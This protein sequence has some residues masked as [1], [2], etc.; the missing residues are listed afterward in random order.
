MRKLKRVASKLATV[1]VVVPARVPA[2]IPAL[3]PTLIPALVLSLVLAAHSPAVAAAAPAPTN[4]ATAS[5]AA[6]VSQIAAHLGRAQGVRA[7]FTQ[8]QTLAAMK[9]PL[10]STGALLFY[11]ERGV[12]WQID[13][14]YRKTWVMSDSGIVTVDAQGHR[15]ANGSAQGARGAAEIAKT[16]RAMLG[17]DLSALYSQFE[18]EASGTPSQ[19]QLHLTPRQPQI[20]QSLRT[21]EMTGGD[22]LRSLRITFANGDTTQYEFSGSAAV[23]ALTPADQSLFGTAQ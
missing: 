10:V 17:G 15:V 9:A 1:P 22:F 19:W 4:A 13:T 23:T 14:P 21:I 11:R 7:R 6:L 2:L 5:D 8:T 20:A 16:M 12:I 3:V 18:V